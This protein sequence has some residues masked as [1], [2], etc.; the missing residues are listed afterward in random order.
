MTH[1]ILAGDGDC[2]LGAN[3]SDLVQQSLSD[4]ALDLLNL[5]DSLIMS[6]AVQEEIDIRSGT[7]LLVVVLA[8]L[9]LGGV[10][11]GGD[12]QQAID[13]RRSG[14]NHIV[15]VHVNHGRLGEDVEVLL[16]LGQA[17][18]GG[19]R[20]IGSALIVG[21]SHDVSGLLLFR[22]GSQ[23]SSTGLDIL[24]ILVEKGEHIEVRILK[25]RVLAILS[26][27]STELRLEASVGLQNLLYRLIRIVMDMLGELLMGGRELWKI[28]HG[29]VG[30]HLA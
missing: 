3:D 8:E 11:L 18:N 27:D 24:G 7:E 13:N 28:W 2:V 16:E 12:R 9:P 25:D 23:I 17:A 14:G 10:E 29:H 21:Q 6:K 1:G 20:S 15:P 22:L 30:V 26:V 5:V 4:S 19:G